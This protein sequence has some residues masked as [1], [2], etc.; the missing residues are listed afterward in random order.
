M[1][2]RREEEEGSKRVEGEVEMRRRRLVGWEMLR[3]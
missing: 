1:K 3:T 2:G